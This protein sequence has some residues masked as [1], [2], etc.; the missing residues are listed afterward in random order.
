MASFVTKPT[1]TITASV[2]NTTSKIALSGITSNREITPDT[3]KT[4]ID[5]LLNVVGKSVIT[6]GMLRTQTEEAVTNG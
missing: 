4:Q 6:A 2:A 3:A 1:V 5:K